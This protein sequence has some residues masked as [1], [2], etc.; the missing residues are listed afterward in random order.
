MAEEKVVEHHWHEPTQGQVVK[1]MYQYLADMGITQEKINEVVEKKV[2]QVLAGKV[3]AWVNSG[4]FDKLLTEAVAQYVLG[5]EKAYEAN[6]YGFH[7]RLRFL[8]QEHLKTLL[9]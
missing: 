1:A 3:D 7:N 9:L 5:E 8:I 6:R 4:R 2:Q